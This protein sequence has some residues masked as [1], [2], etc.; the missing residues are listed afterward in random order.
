MRRYFLLVSVVS[1]TL[2]A[3]VAARAD[4]PAPADSAKPAQAVVPLQDA[5]AKGPYSAKVM[6]GHAAYAARDFQGAIAAYKD[7]IKDD[8]LARE[9]AA[10]EAERD[11]DATRRRMREMIERRYTAPAEAAGSSNA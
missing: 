3:S 9:A 4:T 5:K 8:D 7:A 6:K 11:P 1:S 10:V 2:V